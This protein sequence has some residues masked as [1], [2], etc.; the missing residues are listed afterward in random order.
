MKI[1]G[2]VLFIFVVACRQETPRP[3]SFGMLPRSAISKWTIDCGPP[4]VE[5]PVLRGPD[6]RFARQRTTA[7]QRATHRFV[8]RPPGWSV[9]VDDRDRVVGLCV[10]DLWGRGYSL[11]SHERAEG[12]L[13]RLGG[14]EL[15]SKAI[16][17]G[18]E[19]EPRAITPELLR[20]QQY[21]PIEQRWGGL[22]VPA[23]GQGSRFSCCWELTSDARNYSPIR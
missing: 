18:C 22:M 12:L 4:A 8:C 21:V 1:A 20:W 19:P 17:G 13:R 11:A 15:A 3:L 2:L 23:T 6:L 7:F 5:E 14:A 16:E 9:Y 10:D